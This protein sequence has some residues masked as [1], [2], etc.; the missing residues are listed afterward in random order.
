VLDKDEFHKM[1]DAALLER[2]QFELRHKE[3]IASIRGS[4]R[5]PS[6]F[7]SVMTHVMAQVCMFFMF[8][9][10]MGIGWYSAMKICGS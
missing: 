3:A 10:G 5:A 6:L 1:A 4:K 7:M 9:C 2:K 8:L